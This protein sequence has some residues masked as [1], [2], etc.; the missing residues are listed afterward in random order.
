MSINKV[1][2]T[3]RLTRDAELRATASGTEVLSFSVAVNDRRK[4]PQTGEWEDYANFVDCKMFGTRAEAIS[5]H[6]AKG[7]QVAIDGK[8][9]FSSWER[10]G[11]RRSKLEVVV[12]DI[13]LLGGAK[14][15]EGAAD[16]QP[17][18]ELSYYDEAVEF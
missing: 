10:D 2:I 8:L 5:R 14:A 1:I 15:K 9:R 12:D 18:P 13:E 16:E 4:N 11:Q 17:A 6:V 7:T 3:G